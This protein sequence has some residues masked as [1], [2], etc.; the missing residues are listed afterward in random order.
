MEGVSCWGILGVCEVRETYV[1][2]S[3]YCRG[4]YGALAGGIP[5]IFLPRRE[6]KLGVGVCSYE[7]RDEC[8]GWQVADC[9]AVAEESIPLLFFEGFAL[10]FEFGEEGLTPEVH[11]RR[12]FE[13]AVHVICIFETELLE[14]NAYCCPRH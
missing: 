2:R 11:V 13:E 5:A 1:H 9:L 12:V 3:I 8:R 6:D 14:G 10:A 4:L 7:L